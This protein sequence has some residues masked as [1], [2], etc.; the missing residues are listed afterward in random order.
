MISLA[1]ILSTLLSQDAADDKTKAF[2]RVDVSSEKHLA[3][4]Q[5]LIRTGERGEEAVQAVVEQRFRDLGCHV[6]VV[7]KI[8]CT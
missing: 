1:L 5:E 2:A 3:F 8:H 4:L 7:V 6:E